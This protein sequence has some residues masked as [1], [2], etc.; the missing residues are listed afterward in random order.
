M[1]RKKLT[2]TQSHPNSTK[3]VSSEERFFLVPATSKQRQ[4]EALRA[5]YIDKEA[6][7]D[8]ARKFGYTRAAFH[9]LC[10]RFRNDKQREFFLETK[11]GPKF[12]RTEDS[13]KARVIALRKKNYSVSD[14]SRLLRDEKVELSASSIWSILN[15]EGFEKLPRR[16]DDE[17]PD[18]PRPEAAGYA[19]VRNFDLSERVIETKHAGL[20]IALKILSEMNIYS[21]P[22]KLNWYGSEMIPSGHAFMSSL[23]LKLVGKP[24]KTH[25]M[26]FVFDEGVALGVGLNQMPKRSYITEYS[27]R[28]THEETLKFLSLWLKELRKRGV[29]DGQSFNLDFQSLPY[30]GDKD[31]VEKHYVSMRSR[32]QKAILVFFAQ[33]S[34]SKIFCY[35]NAD[36]RKGEEA[37]EILKFVE[38]WKKETGS[39]PPHLVF[40]SKLTTIPVLSTINKM[41][42]TFVTLRRRTKSVMK[43]IQKIEDSAWRKIELKKVA[44]QYRHPKVVDQK[45]RM[46]NYDGELRQI[47]VKDLGH[48]QPT[49]IIT[50]DLKTGVA[51]MIE[52]YAMRMLIENAIANGVKFFHTTALSTSVAICIDFDVLLTLIGQATYHILAS[53]QRGY[54]TAGGD[55]INREFIDTP[56]KIFVGKKEIEIRLH[57]RRNNAILKQ[58]GLLG[59]PFTTPWI[60]GKKLIITMR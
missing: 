31:V 5:F 55:V 13:T 28:V 2:T 47:M 54:E 38:F 46:N 44:R 3:Y 10:H 52:R 35:S 23:I 17:R 1:P 16:R 11:R 53:K 22:D 27:Q 36:L 39:N 26:D 60:P 45:I 7:G 20:F 34:K 37:N 12:G 40:D 51:A 50:N 33:D 30:F 56:G 14:I 6:A 18:W 49:I 29:V 57:K 41:K 24:R 21:F 59:V 4:Y 25:V 58:S 8:I 9:V 32:R 42:I 15:S 48:E 43:E 19:D